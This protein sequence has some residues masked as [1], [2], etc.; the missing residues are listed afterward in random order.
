MELRPDQLRHHHE[1]SPRASWDYALTNEALPQNYRGI[2]PW[3]Y[4]YHVSS[5]NIISHTN[6]MPLSLPTIS[7]VLH[8]KIIPT[9]PSNS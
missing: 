6:T 1:V 9:Q 4:Q 3:T 8:V 2:T 5:I 7:F